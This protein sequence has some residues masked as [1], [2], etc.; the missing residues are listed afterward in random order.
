[1]AT[2][3][4]LRVTE[5]TLP[6]QYVRDYPNAIRGRRDT[7]LR[8]AVKQYT[9]LE[10]AEDCSEQSVTIIATG[11]NGFPKEI[12]EPLFDNLYEYSRRSQQFKIRS[13]WMA[14]MANQGASGVMNDNLLGDDPCWLD[15]SRDLLHL[16]NTFSEQMPRPLVGL[17]HS[18][19]CA[20]LA[21]LSLYHPRLFHTLVFIDPAILPE[22]PLKISAGLVSSLRAERWNSRQEAEAAL[23]SN[24]NFLG[25]D[26]KVL[27][28]YI[29]YGLRSGPSAVHPDAQGT[30]AILTTSKHQESWMYVRPALHPPDSKIDRLLYPD[31]SHDDQPQK[32]S[33][34]R[35]QQN[36]QVSLLSHR[37]ESSGMFGQIAHLR[38]SVLYLFGGASY[39][40]NAR[41]RED[42]L[43][44]TGTGIGGS[45]GTR[46]GMVKAKTWAKGGHMLP[47][48]DGIV[49]EVAHASGEWLEEQ[50]KRFE[51]EEK[52]LASWDS[53][54]SQARGNGLV[55]SQ[56]WMDM[57]KKP[58]QTKRVA[59]GSSKL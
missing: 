24:R 9:P 25:W 1:M 46:L 26:E 36:P 55:L 7:R 38:P 18:L 37:A 15:H 43:D 14:D 27:E 59:G 31:L 53:M 10:E 56:A 33:A 42:T 41:L 13:I 34:T 51:E 20:Q 47:V 57:V 48:E 6:A 58:T 49:Q 16:I 39:L 44:I 11:A 40:L 50:V 35:M 5:H 32:F 45:G 22:A 19:G 23:R 21:H 3:A 29:K 28:L 2:T 30:E 17:G 12:Y 52:F 8:L 4:F 54:K